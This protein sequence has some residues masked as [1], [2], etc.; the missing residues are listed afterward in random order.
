MTAHNS[1]TTP[2]PADLQP[3]DWVTVD[4]ALYDWVN[5]ELSLRDRIIWERRGEKRPEYPYVSLFRDS[6][7][8]QGAMDEQRRRSLDAAGLIVGID[9]GAG[10]PVENEVL[11]YQPVQFTLT[12][13]AH[14]TAEAGAADANTDAFAMLSKARRTLGRRDVVET[15]EAAGLS[16]VSHESVVDLSEVVNGEWLSRAALDVVFGTASVMSSK[17]GFIDKV[18]VTFPLLGDLSPFLIDAS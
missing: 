13:Q 4:A 17:V 15:L 2:P 5:K 9:A 14:T 10:D 18:E 12:L 7:V 16:V 6:E 1:A 3:C 11:N 8:D